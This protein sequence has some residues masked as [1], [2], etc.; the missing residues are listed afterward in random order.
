ML[1]DA[2]NSD[3]LLSEEKCLLIVNLKLVVLPLAM[4]GVILEHV[5]LPSTITGKYY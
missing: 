1:P 3:G 4:D 5:C 2:K